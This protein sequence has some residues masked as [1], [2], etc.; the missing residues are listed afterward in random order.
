M[1][2]MMTVEVCRLS[3]NE[4]AAVFCKGFS[5][6]CVHTSPPCQRIFFAIAQNVK[7]SHLRV[8]KSCLV[9]FPLI[10][11]IDGFKQVPKSVI[12]A[13]KE[14]RY[15]PQP[16][17]YSKTTYRRLPSCIAGIAIMQVVH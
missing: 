5:A 10:K 14:N 12:P 2:A 11:V 9:V 7:K 15:L 13:S 6:K 16:P 4:M 8:F 1:P 17:F 3:S